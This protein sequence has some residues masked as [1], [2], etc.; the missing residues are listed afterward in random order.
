MIPS[1]LSLYTS[2]ATE[3][4]VCDQW[5][6]ANVSPLYKKDDET[7]KSK[8]RPISLLCVPGKLM[9]MCVTLTVTTHLTLHELSHNHQWGIQG[10]SFN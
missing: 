8:H 4:C 5:K 3:T 10:R 7:D 9:E 6:R 1:L 2:R